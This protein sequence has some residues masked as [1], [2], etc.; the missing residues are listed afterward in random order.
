VLAELQEL[1]TTAEDSIEELRRSLRMMREDFDLATGIED[2]VRTF[3]ERTQLPVRFERS[4]AV[5]D[6]VAPESSLALFRV[7]QECLSNAVKH[8][9]AKQVDVKLHFSELTVLLSVKDDGQGFELGKPKLGH[10]GLINMRE[11]ANK[12]GGAVTIESAPGA[13]AT[14]SFS[15]PVESVFQ[16]G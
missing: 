14:V 5:S 1:K 16:P 2:Y 3:A 11:R 13:G 15:V 4:G 10:Y 9:H 12:V 8:A 7:L 6:H